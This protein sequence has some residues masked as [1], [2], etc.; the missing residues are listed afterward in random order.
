MSVFSENLRYLRESKQLNQSDMLA[1]CGFARSTWNNYENDTSWP[2]FKDLQKISDYFGILESDLI[3]TK[4]P[5]AHLKEVYERYKNRNNAHLKSQVNAHLNALNEPNE[6]YDNAPSTPYNDKEKNGENRKINNNPVTL[7]EP[8]DQ[9]VTMND[10]AS[11]LKDIA[12]ANL[13]QAQA[14]TLAQKNIETMLSML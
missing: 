13:E 5:E 2:N 11:T 6:S 4:I 3:H 14:N 9:E 10:I 7:P 1:E 12:S 8:K